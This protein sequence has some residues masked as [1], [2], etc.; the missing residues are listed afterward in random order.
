MKNN[1]S[2]MYWNKIIKKIQKKEKMEEL[3]TL[4]IENLIEKAFLEA[5]Y[6]LLQVPNAT[7][8]LINKVFAI[9]VYI[10]NIANSQNIYDIYLP[11][12]QKKI[13]QLR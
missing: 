7:P 11:Y 5:Y 10:N 12:L 6:R 13:K 3:I 9:P 8:E 4:N 1:I 2:I